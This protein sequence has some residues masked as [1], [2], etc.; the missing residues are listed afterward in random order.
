MKTIIMAVFISSLLIAA[1]APAADFAIPVPSAPG[2][3]AKSNGKA[4]I[5]YSNAK[6]GYVMV[7]YA[8]RTRQAVKAIVKGPS[9]SQYVYAL[10]PGAY[11]TL[12][13][14]DG[15]GGYTVGVYEQI[16][17]TKYAVANTAS[18]KVKLAD[19]FAP[20]LRPNQFVNYS[21]DS[22]AA[23]VAAE[24]ALGA[25]GFLDKIA[26]VYGYV[27][28]NISYDKDL[29]QNVKTGYLPDIDAVLERKKGICFD[30]AALMT[31]MLRCLGIP[32]KLVVGYSGQVY[33]AWINAY[34]E[35]TGWV[36]SVIYFDGKT[37]RL[38]DPT[39]ASTGGKSDE[40]MKYI[41]D[42]GNYKAKFVY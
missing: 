2:K 3:E 38:M 4:V 31:A 28:E 1:R 41:G 16:A 29:A 24:L 17:G 32:C 25:P 33:H 27:T 11:E 13:L 21:K 5:D 40:V 35:E 6:D 9:G 23:G 14:S 8:A 12:P 26:T 18:V 19:E 30:Y 37:W 39:F 10:R 22:R 7:R 20:F 34:S 36:D 15:D 42:G